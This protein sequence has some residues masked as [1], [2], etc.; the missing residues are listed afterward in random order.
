MQCKP[1]CRTSQPPGCINL[2]S[3]DTTR[4]Q[5]QRPKC[6]KGSPIFTAPLEAA[7]TTASD[8]TQ[9]YDR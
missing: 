3:G 5:G 7:Q 9:D 1:L 6:N 8:A 2:L 4:H